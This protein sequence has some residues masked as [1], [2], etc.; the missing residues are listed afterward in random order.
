M[1]RNKGI[2]L[3][4]ENPVSAATGIVPKDTV[5]GKLLRRIKSKNV[6]YKKRMVARSKALHSFKQGAEKASRISARN[7]TDEGSLVERGKLSRTLKAA[8]YADKHPESVDRSKSGE[9]RAKY[10]YRN[11][12]IAKR[13]KA[14]FDKGLPMGK[15]KKNEALLSSIIDKIR[16]GRYTDTGEEKPVHHRSFEVGQKMART[17]KKKTG[18]YDRDTPEYKKQSGRREKLKKFFK[19][20]HNKQSSASAGFADTVNNE[21]LDRLNKKIVSKYGSWKDKQPESAQSDNEKSAR[22]Q[23]IRKA[24]SGAARRMKGR[25]PLRLKT[26]ASEGLQKDRRV[27]KALNKKA[28]K[29]GN[30]ESDQTAHKQDMKMLAKGA[31]K[32]RKNEGSGYPNVKGDDATSKSLKDVRAK[33]IKARKELKAKG[34]KRTK[35]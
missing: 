22:Q 14:R 2:G 9:R 11:I 20:A 15:P 12:D 25:K 30:L 7:K 28:A 18:S 19:K 24:M 34:L 10:R 8:K 5:K 32:S 21:G 17:V 6:P 3:D 4:K 31:L 27:L 33:A 1:R 35:S 13:Q 26:M 23:R 16:E 29:K